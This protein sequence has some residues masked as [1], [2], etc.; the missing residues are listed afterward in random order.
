MLIEAGVIDA[1]QLQSA[2]GHQRRWGGRIGQ[3]LVDLKFVTEAQIVD[4]LSRKLGYE[5]VNLAALSFGSPLDLAM[6]LVPH[7]FAE[8]HLLFPL[9]A[10]A[11]SISVAMA[12]PTNVAVID[13]LAFRTGRKVKVALAGDR[14]I[15]EAVQRFY[16]AEKRFVEAISIDDTDEMPVEMLAPLDGNYVQQLDDFFS[17][18]AAAAPV[19]LH[20]TLA[21][22]PEAPRP[23]LTAEAKLAAAVEGLRLEDELTGGGALSRKSAAAP[24][25]PPAPEF[26]APVPAALP[27]EDEP[28]SPRLAVILD[29]FER[30]A[31]AEGAPPEMARFARAMGALV[32]LLLKRG[33]V[34]E[35]EL[36]N[37]LLR[38]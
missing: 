22:P 8:R 4:A 23:P 3:A 29:D 25:A 11:H 31:R 28:V 20:Q 21:E 17:R 6:R 32:R 34:Q 12:D 18:P 38:R 13:E 14:A 35:Q 10:D 1:A 26:L 16:V 2:L 36:V 9:A 33:I 15:A 37:E 24:P 7:D 5:A 19:P 30:M 27:E